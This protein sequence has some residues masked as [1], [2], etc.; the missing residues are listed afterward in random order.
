[1]HKNNH[2]HFVGINGIGMS[3]IAKI[4][5][6]QGYIVS[7]C[8]LALPLTNVQELIDTGCKISNQHSSA[9]CSDNSITVVVYSSDVPYD[10]PELVYARNRGIKTLQRAAIL[11]QIM[12]NKFSIGI[13]GSHGKTTTSSMISHIF[14]QAQIDPTIIV[15]GIMHNIQNNARYG[16]GDYV[17]AETDESDRSHLLLPVKLAVLTNIDFEHANVY[18]NLQEVIDTFTQFV[19]QLPSDGRAIICIDD[20][21]IAKMNLKNNLHVITYGT[22]AIAD[23][24]AINIQLGAD[25]STFDIFD[26]H[27]QTTLGTIHINMPSIYNVLNATAATTTALQVGIS[28]SVITQALASFQGID[29]RFTYKGRM[30]NP[31]AD[32][33]DDYGHHPTEIYHTLITA[34]RKTKNKLI[35]VFQ[36]QRYSR[37]YHLWDEFIKVLNTA[38]IDHLIITDI[39]A[40]NE[41][42]IENITSQQLVEAIQSKNPSCMVQYIP[43]QSDLHNIKIAVLNKAGN[44]DLILLLGAG[45]VNKLAEQLL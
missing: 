3:G 2:F 9:L 28:F 25:S 17:V 19:N 18:K 30:S 23:I 13:A 36:P 11:A 39:Y 6:K 7:G 34:R 37:T 45:K 22:K 29:R 32:I 14:M 15:G 26:R 10:N 27:A 4:L 33:F 12:H 5:H 38:A 8:D 41:P 1:M 31:A 40:A 20:E 42:T 43:Y 44:D 35:V 24:Q 16:T 21:N